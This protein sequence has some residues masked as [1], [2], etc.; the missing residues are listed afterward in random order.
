MPDRSPRPSANLRTGKAGLNIPQRTTQAFDNPFRQAK[1][2]CVPHRRALSDFRK[3]CSSY[4]AHSV[5]NPETRRTVHAQSRN[6]FKV[7]R[8]VAKQAHPAERQT[9]SPVKAFRQNPRQ[10]MPDEL[11]KTV[12]SNLRQPGPLRRCRHACHLHATLTGTEPFFVQDR[13]NL[14]SP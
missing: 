10:E 8:T 7:T 12:R 5:P 14:L 4:L 6:H 13:L 9:K 11:P 2:A 3:T 1:P